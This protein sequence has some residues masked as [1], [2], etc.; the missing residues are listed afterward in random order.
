MAIY[1]AATILESFALNY[2]GGA[3]FLAGTVHTGP[4]L[5]LKDIT[6]DMVHWH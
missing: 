3:I 4:A 1:S 6:A 5:I 2:T